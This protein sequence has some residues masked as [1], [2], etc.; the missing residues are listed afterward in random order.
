MAALYRSRR[1][2]R[3]PR[4]RRRLPK[5]S[6]NWPAAV[7]AFET[8]EAGAEPAEW[9]VETYARQSLLDA[10]LGVRLELAAA[11]AGGALLELGE[12]PVPER[13]WL[14]E[15]RRAFPPLRIGRFL[16]H[17][18]HWRRE[19]PAG[20][21]AVEI[22]AASAFGT[23]EHPSTRGCLLALDRLARRRRFRTPARHRHRQR[24]PRD[25]RGETAAPQGA[26]QRHRPGVGAGRPPHA[27][28]NGA[29]AAGASSNAGL[30]APRRRSAGYDLVFANILARPLALMAARSGAVG[31]ARR[32]GD[33]LRTIAAA[34]GERA[35]RLSPHGLAL[36]FR[37]PIEGWSTL[38]LRRGML[39]RGYK[40]RQRAEAA[41]RGAPDAPA[42]TPVSE[43]DLAMKRHVPRTVDSPGISERWMP[44]SASER[45]SSA[46][47][48]AIGLMPA[49]PFRQLVLGSGKETHD[50]HND[51]SPFHGAMHKWPL[52]PD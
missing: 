49:P 11:A 33:P 18:S 24:H 23:G 41:G 27:R 7:S 40:R 37:V 44:I 35:R 16:I 8:R 13:D 34:G 25:R 39:R 10:A 32:G 43:L 5:S 4:R 42:K 3:A 31:W 19:V 22:D 52:I 38:V 46:H 15:N 17:G 45:S 47:Q 20:S 30:P 2:S 26:G 9:R 12:E 14:A 28:R 21:I 29:G 6:M 36:D 48:L 1:G 50:E 51:T